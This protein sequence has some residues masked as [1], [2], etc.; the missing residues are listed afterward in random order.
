MKK[1]IL[2][3]ILI[4]ALLVL[5]P[6]AQ[7][8]LRLPPAALIE[9]EAF[10]GIAAEDAI[11]PEGVTRI[12]E[13]A[14][15]YSRLRSVALPSTLEYIA[16]NAFE[17]CPLTS[18]RAE[19]GTFAAIWGADSG[20]TVAENN[21]LRTAPAAP[22]RLAATQGTDSLVELRWEAAPDAEFYNIYE[23]ID[24]VEA[25]VAVSMEPQ[26]SLA[27][28]PEGEHTYTVRSCGMLG[29]Q[30]QV[31]AACASITVSV[32][33][34]GWAA[35][36]VI[37]SVKESPANC[38]TLEWKG[39]AASFEVVECLPGGESNVVA[40]TKS[41]SAYLK[42]IAPGTHV[43]AVRAIMADGSTAL[44]RW[45]FVQPAGAPQE[46]VLSETSPR[47]TVGNTLKV[48]ATVLP[49]KAVGADLRWSVSDP[50]VISFENGTLRAL[51]P[52]AATLTASTANGASASCEVVVFP[53]SESY[54][55]NKGVLTRYDGAETEIVIP[56]DLGITE[57]SGFYNNIF[58]ARSSVF[59]WSE[60]YDKI[61]SVVI[62][63]GVTVIGDYAFYGLKSLESVV[64]PSTV[65]T[66]GA[67]AFGNCPA[68][69]SVTL[70][71]NVV[72]LGEGVFSGCIALTSVHLPGGLTALPDS[73]FSSCVALDGV[74]LPDSLTSIGNSA[75]SG[76][77]SL[78]SLSIPQNVREIGKE[79]FQSTA[80]TS[81]TLPEGL[82][83]LSDYLFK[84]CANLTYVN[85]PESVTRIGDGVFIGCGFTS[86]TV[87]GN[88]AEIGAGAFGS[89]E[90]LTSVTLEN[91]VNRLGNAV[92][93][94]CKNL[95]SVQMA[96]SVTAIGDRIFS[97]CES[98]TSVR[99]S[100]NITK[101]PE[102]AFSDCKS[103]TGITVPSLVT[104]IGESAFL[105]CEALTTVSLPSGLL[106]IG[107]SAFYQ[108]SALKYISLP[109]SLRSLGTRA[110]EQC[111]SLESIHIPGSL[112]TVEPYTFARCGSLKYLTFGEGVRSILNDAFLYCS[113]LEEVTLPE[114][115][116]SLNACSFGSC[117][118]LQRAAL[119]DSFVP[120]LNNHFD[121]C[122]CTF[123]VK[124]GSLAEQWCLDVQLPYRIS[125]T[126]ALTGSGTPPTKLTLNADALWLHPGEAFRLTAHAEAGELE[127]EYS[128]TSDHGEVAEVNAWTG[129]VTAN[130]IGTAKIT[131]TSYNG[132][133]AWCDVTVLPAGYEREDWLALLDRLGTQYRWMEFFYAFLNGG[134]ADPITGT[135]VQGINLAALCKDRVQEIYA[136]TV[137]YTS[138]ATDHFLAQAYAI[139]DNILCRLSGVEEP[140]EI[141]ASYFKAG[142][143]AAGFSED[144]INAVLTAQFIQHV[145]NGKIKLPTYWSDKSKME[146]F[147][148]HYKMEIDEISGFKTAADLLNAVLTVVRKSYVYTFVSRSDLQVYIDALNASGDKLLRT[149]AAMLEETKTDNGLGMLLAVNGVQS[150][151]EKL[152]KKAL[153]D[154]TKKT[155]KELVE[156]APGIG[157][158]L[159]GAEIGKFIGTTFNSLALNVDAIQQAAYEA[160]AAI[161]SAKAYEDVFR[162]A[163][164]HF[165]W[166]PLNP[167]RFADFARAYLAFGELL[168]QA[169][170]AYAKL[171]AAVDKS[172][173]AQLRNLITSQNFNDVTADAKSF[174][175]LC[176]TYMNDDLIAY[177]NAFF[178]DNGVTRLL[179]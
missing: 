55:V 100:A 153:S 11:I 133:L 81:V 149:S 175:R 46:I 165:Q 3:L 99:L 177:G 159:R 129:T 30:R 33:G 22:S 6:A 59:G 103:L 178:P 53:A 152:A 173:Y 146:Y 24:G 162:S 107:P 18:V 49:D 122:P 39:T 168:G 17:G 106:S 26:I 15:A 130:A 1:P 32:G 163:Y 112:Q 179:K 38:L 43:Y 63:E 68:L 155:V 142:L 54:T 65:T 4:T 145:N 28:V 27:A 92:F 44:S 41:R 172:N 71:D 45:Y 37:S 157:M 56:S 132:K 174:A 64:I 104:A 52:G 176:R 96:D 124:S 70:S 148:E 164:E 167:E 36:P 74:T 154:V 138:Y 116:Q 166:Y 117:E 60:N 141:S 61:R 150:V 34:A 113:S 91:G 7:A 98:L 108:A 143:K 111:E 171:P 16:P 23:V 135:Q 62:P 119:P 144:F 9:D 151:M 66:V 120:T 80:L 114:G 156:A 140:S 31:G 40:A 21:D 79:A 95:V 102:E 88:V 160:E 76:C 69:R 86:F 72:F 123:I 147:D 25:L 115:L 57:L 83:S 20:Y 77:H 8:G 2:T 19:E 13:R 161:S 73:A 85:I 136:N 82:A 29:S 5:C 131:V 78:S 48:Y 127:R 118:S 47:L 58:S 50:G 97:G 67:Y 90:S 126:S 10:Y 94:S 105:R 101:I 87:P 170:D 158:F 35:A 125:G 121:G 128:Y 137:G 139:A 12:G 109:G 84:W 42:D 14:F 75:F 51:A 93:G 169:Y 134:G 110:F 89:C